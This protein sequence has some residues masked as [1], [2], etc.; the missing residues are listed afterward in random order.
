[1]LHQPGT[2]QPG[3]GCVVLCHLGT[4][5]RILSMGCLETEGAGWFEPGCGVAGLPSTPHRIPNFKP[6]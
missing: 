4:V 3:T 5:N 2:P 1:M 6:P